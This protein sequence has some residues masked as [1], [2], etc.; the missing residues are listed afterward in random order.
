MGRILWKSPTLVGRESTPSILIASMLWIALQ[1]LT[2]LP[3]G[4]H[5]RRE[6]AT[7]GMA[8]TLGGT[9]AL[10][11]NA[12]AVAA[13]SFPSSVKLANGESFPLASFGLQIYDDDTAERL[14]L[15]AI[16]AGYRNFFA[17]VLA[18]NQV[19]FA[20]AVK[21]SKVPR[22]EL[23]ICGSVVSNRALDEETAYELTALGCAE[24]MKAFSEGG[25]SQ[26][27]M[28]M[29]DYPGPTDACIRGQWRAFKE[30]QARGLVRSLA[31]SNFSPKQ[32]D[33]VC[34]GSLATR[35]MVNQ[36]P[37]CVGYH[38]PGLIAANGRR[39]VHV[40]AWSPLGNGRLTRF[41]RDKGPIRALCTEIGSRYS[42]SPYQVALRWLTQYGAS[43]TVEASS[44]THFKED[45]EIF[46]FALSKEE[47]AAL[48]ELN[49]MPGYEGSVTRPDA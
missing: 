9:T 6:F 20:R 46:D 43:Y 17:S 24:N 22:E 48:E 49:V 4:W 7:A 26:L 32:L 36:L 18:N 21:R 5:T 33:V 47:M 11:G 16:E 31:V 15:L 35:P 13:T 37:L 30:M 23:F 25:I 10:G 42:K 14:T 29:L 34:T 41:S 38:D 12:A 45:I 44:A 19:G 3:R 40:Q 8:A 2:L 28:I 1:S 27:D 39:G